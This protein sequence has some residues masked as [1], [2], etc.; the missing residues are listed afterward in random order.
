MA[1]A[2]VCKLLTAL[3]LDSTALSFSAESLLF[4]SMSFSQRAISSQPFEIAVELAFIREAFPEM[5]VEFDS[6][7]SARAARSVPRRFDWP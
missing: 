3:A 4:A 2:L 5:V 1:N 7:A 6:S